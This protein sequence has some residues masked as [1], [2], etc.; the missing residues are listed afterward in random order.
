MKDEYDFSNG[1]RGAIISTEGK[2]RVGIYL[3]TPVL[4][5]L[6]KQAEQRGMGRQSL[7]NEVLTAYTSIDGAVFEALK[8]QATKQGVNYLDL[9]N[10]VLKSYVEQFAFFEER[11]ANGSS[12][13]YNAVLAKVPDIPVDER[14]QLSDKEI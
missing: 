4:D 1:R 10:E 2:T 12:E 5:K 7:I 13:K 11:T 14:N 3:D 8:M 6:R 9:V